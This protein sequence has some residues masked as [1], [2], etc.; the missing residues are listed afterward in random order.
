MLLGLGPEDEVSY[1]A[2][3]ADRNPAAAKSDISEIVL[4]RARDAPMSSATQENDTADDIQ[5]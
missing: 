2:A 1:E 3:D 5:L 4:R